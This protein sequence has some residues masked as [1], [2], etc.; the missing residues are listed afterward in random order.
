MQVL[1]TLPID[2][3]RHMWSGPAAAGGH[4]FLWAPNE[5]DE[6][7]SGQASRWSARG[8]ASH[9]AQ[10][11]ADLTNA[12]SV[13]G[14]SVRDARE[15][16]GENSESGFG[17]NVQTFGSSSLQPQ[18]SKQNSP[19]R[20]SQLHLPFSPLHSFVFFYTKHLY[21]SESGYRFSPPVLNQPVA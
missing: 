9:L 7:G 14:D 1:P 20:I 2:A 21:V 18:G 6:G 17:D 11:T 15:T 16:F 8:G 4:L 19:V 5:I 12:T 10:S 3:E 13:D